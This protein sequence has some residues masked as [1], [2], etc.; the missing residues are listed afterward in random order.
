[1]TNTAKSAS[2]QLAKASWLA[3]LLVLGINYFANLQRHEGGGGSGSMIFTVVALVLLLLGLVSGVLSLTGI[4]K[5]GRKGILVPALIGIVLCLAYL[6][7]MGSVFYEAVSN[8]SQRRLERLAEDLSHDLPKMVD[9]DT[10]L[11]SVTAGKGELIVDY[12]FPHHESSQVNIPAF[13]QAIGPAVKK[14]ACAQFSSVLPR[15]FQYH[16]RYK[17][18]DQVQLADVVVKGTDC[19]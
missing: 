13:A 1:V 14:L 7:F 9:T 18:A 17:S 2:V 16:A 6:S 11:T 4:R 5:H 3:I 8:R 12:T 10:Q 19:P 15:E